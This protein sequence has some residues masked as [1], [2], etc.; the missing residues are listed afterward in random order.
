[1]AFSNHLVPLLTEIGDMGNLQR[2]IQSDPGFKHGIYLYSGKP[3]NEI[4]ANRFN[5]R[6]NNIDIYLTAF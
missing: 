6:S 2:M 3:V 1:M 5:V 4:V